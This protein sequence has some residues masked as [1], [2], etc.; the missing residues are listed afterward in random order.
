MRSQSFRTRVSESMISMPI[1]AVLASV[2]W[3][4]PDIQSVALWGGLA[5]VGMMTY[6]MIA[7][8]TQY[9]LIRVRSRMISLSFLYVFLAFPQLHSFGIH[10]F[11]AVCM[12]GAYFLLFR[13]Y[14]VYAPQGYFF[15]AFF[16]V[17]VGSFAFP[18]LLLLVPF[19][20]FSS[21]RHLRTLTG[22][23][24]MAALLGLFLPYWLL[25]PVFL[26][27]REW[28]SPYLAM[29]DPSQLTTLLDFSHVPLSQWVGSGLFFLIS[30]VSLI[31]FLRTAYNDK[32][33]TRQYYYLLLLQVL[34]LTLIHF[35]LP[36]HFITTLPLCLVTLAPFIGHYFALAKGRGMNVWFILWILLFLLLGV[37]NYFDLW[38][39]LSTF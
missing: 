21:E 16:L 26:L 20:F 19:L 15:H 29:W 2:I 30:A 37:A 10:F 28:L 3:M 13:T 31:H 34:P 1:L 22:K 18:P 24:A 39:L 9:Q 33:R 14:G 23:S 11:P 8:N 27:A 7:W 6:V 25:L 5:V 4:I 32:I 38:T 35:A 12:L 36:Q 17:G